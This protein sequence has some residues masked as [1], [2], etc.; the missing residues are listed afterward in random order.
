[1]VLDQQWQNPALR[2]KLMVRLGT[3][4]AACSMGIG[5]WSSLGR[6][7]QYALFIRTM[8]SVVQNWGPT[9]SKVKFPTWF[10]L[11]RYD[12][13]LR[14][15]GE[16]IIAPY[17]HD[18][19]GRL[20]PGALPAQ[21]QSIELAMERL[22][23]VVLPDPAEFLPHTVRYGVEQGSSHRPWAFI[24]SEPVAALRRAMGIAHQE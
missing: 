2:T 23:C 24:F 15:E 20:G 11:D 19:S 13:W 3:Q 16:H 22:G 21:F 7:A 1:M 6:D 8:H 9:H 17:V 5:L 14:K 18:L 10:N 4:M 12:K